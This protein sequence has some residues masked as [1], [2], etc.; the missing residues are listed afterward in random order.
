MRPMVGPRTGRRQPRTATPRGAPWPEPQPRY[1]EHRLAQR[2]G[3]AEQKARRHD[4]ARRLRDAVAGEEPTEAPREPVEAARP[5]SPPVEQRYLVNDTTVEKL[6]ELL[7]H[8]PNGLLLFRDALSGFLHTMDRAGHENDR[9]FYCEAWN[10][11][12]AYTYDRIGRGTL[13]ILAAS[14]S[15][16]GRVD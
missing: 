9:A 7:N 14:L 16:P 2:M 3:L 15:V 11:T 4:L 8:H 5:E 1:E 12:G 6:G 13:D 10:G